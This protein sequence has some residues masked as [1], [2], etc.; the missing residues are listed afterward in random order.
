VSRVLDRRSTLLLGVSLQ[1]AQLRI[2]GILFLVGGFLDSADGLPLAA[3]P[4]ETSL[5]H[6]DAVGLPD[7]AKGILGLFEGDSTVLGAGLQ[8]SPDP[9]GHRGASQKRA[10]S[11]LASR[12]DLVGDFL[13]GVGLGDLQ[14]VLPNEQGKECQEMLLVDLVG[15]GFEG[16]CTLVGVV[17]DRSPVRGGRGELCAH[18][19]S[20]FVVVVFLA[21]EKP[22]MSRERGCI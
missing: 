13:V 20:Q 17:S 14:K 9:A 6:L 18:V 16:P 5:V 10:I 7:G 15:G 12:R 11:C 22:E 4:R 1:L 19:G 3:G 21:R 2:R 8:G